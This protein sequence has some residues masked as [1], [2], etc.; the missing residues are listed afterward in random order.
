MST[1][2]VFLIPI[3]IA[4]VPLAFVVAHMSKTLSEIRDLQKRILV[5]LEKQ[6]GGIA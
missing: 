2:D 3:A 1:L 5:A 4:L 6:S